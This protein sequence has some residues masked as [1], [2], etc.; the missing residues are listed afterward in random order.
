MP[1]LAFVGPAL[2]FLNKGVSK[3]ADKSDTN[4]KTSAAITLLS[5]GAGWFGINPASLAAVGKALVALG[6]LLQSIAG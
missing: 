1:Y 3:L 6:T 5:A 2:R 4:P